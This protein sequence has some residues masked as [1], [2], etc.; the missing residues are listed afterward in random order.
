M[1]RKAYDAINENYG[2]AFSFVL[3]LAN[4]MGDVSLPSFYYAIYEAFNHPQ[5]EKQKE[6][7]ALSVINLLYSFHFLAFRRNN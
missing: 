5:N 4:V 6:T 3:I 1:N 7:F 2:V